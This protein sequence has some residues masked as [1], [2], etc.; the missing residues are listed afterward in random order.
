LDALKYTPLPFW[1]FRHAIR[2][3]FGYGHGF[4]GEDLP[5]SEFFFVGGINTMRGFKFGRAG[6]V[7]SSN[8]A[9]GANKQLIVNN[10]IIFPLLPD[11]KLNGV[12]FFDYGKGFAQGE[13]LDFNLRKAA[14]FE[15]R[16]L[17]PFGPLRAAYGLNL[18]PRSGE[19]KAQ[20]A[21]SV[22]SVF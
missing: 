2:G 8:R 12:L 6:P 14:G 15:V 17:S 20:F 16:W 9:A 13:K 22:G 19:K 11:A 5:V 3:R 1:D 18:S 7:T 10:D 4:G 21:F